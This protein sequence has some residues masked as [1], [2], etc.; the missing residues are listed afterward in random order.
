VSSGAGHITLAAAG[1]G[2]TAYLNAVSSTSTSLRASVSL[3]KP[4]TGGG[5]YL[6]LV[7][8]KVVS[9]NYQLRL[10]YLATGEVQ[11]SIVAAPSGTAALLQTI[12]LPGTYAAGDVLLTRLDVTGTSPTTLSAKVWRQGSAEPASWQL[13]ATDSA[14][15]LQAAGGIGIA[16]YLSGTATN[17]PVVVTVDDVSAT[18]AG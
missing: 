13:T 17:A 2:P 10:K 16:P 1:A 18:A 8:R 11:A 7:G 6:S 12:T 3:D 5:L 14:S 15:G 4:M 9:G